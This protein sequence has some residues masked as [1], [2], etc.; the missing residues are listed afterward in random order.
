MKIPL[1]MVPFQMTRSCSFRG[2]YHLETAKRLQV[3][4]RLFQGVIFFDVLMLL[5][6]SFASPSDRIRSYQIT[7]WK[8][9][10][11]SS[12]TTNMGRVWIYG[13][14]QKW[15]VWIIFEHAN[16]WS[17]F[18]QNGMSLFWGA[19]WRREIPEGECQRQSEFFVPRMVLLG[20]LVHGDE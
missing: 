2:V 7:W 9:L 4:E 5:I 19:F 20:L 14:F 12:S 1:K 3:W 6:L 18:L 16:V 17:I 8:D 10:F 15:Y 13:S 11:H